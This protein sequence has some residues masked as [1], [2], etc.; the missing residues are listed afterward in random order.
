V[1]FDDVV[2]ASI[3]FLDI[4]WAISRCLGFA[5]INKTYNDRKI[6]KKKVTLWFVRKK[7]K[8]MRV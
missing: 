1:A 6:Y 3:L 4:F 2:A 5:I 7:K 8:E